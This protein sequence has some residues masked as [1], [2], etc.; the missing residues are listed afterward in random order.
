MT[1]AEGHLYKLR[2]DKGFTWHMALEKYK[3]EVCVH[4]EGVRGGASMASMEGL[5]MEQTSTHIVTY[6]TILSFGTQ[7]LYL[8]SV[9]SFG[10]PQLQQQ[11]PP[12]LLQLQKA[13]DPNTHTCFASRECHRGTVFSHFEYLLAIERNERGR[14]LARGSSRRCGSSSR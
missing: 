10:L 9:A 5:C 3:K 1:G 8:P 6:S 13:E 11:C 14:K 7:I 2:A 4:E 12:A